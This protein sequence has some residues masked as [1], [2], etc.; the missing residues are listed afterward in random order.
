MSKFFTLCILAVLLLSTFACA[1]VITGTEKNLDD[2]IAKDKVSI[3]KFYAPWCGHC[4]SLA[5]EFEKAADALK[6][7]ASLVK[8][9]CTVEKKLA[10]KYDIKGFPTLIVFRKGEKVENYEGGR[11]AEEI[12]SYVRS[13]S[14]PLFTPVKSQK[15][16]DELIAL[17]LGV[18][19]VKTASEDGDVVT[20]LTPIAKDLSKVVAFAVGTDASIA[21][22]APMESI[23]FYSG[24]KV[25]KYT[26][27]LLSSDFE[28]KFTKFL[29]FAK[30]ATFGEVTP[31]SFKNYLDISNMKFPLGYLFVT[32]LVCTE[33]KAVKAIAEKMRPR[34]IFASVD[35][36]LYGGF[37][38]QLSLPKD[39][40]TGFVIEWDHKHYV[41]PLDKKIESK[42]LEEFITAVL[43]KKISPTLKSE[44]AP[45]TETTN[46]LTTLVGTTF[47]KY[48]QEKKPMFVLFYAP[49][50]GHCKKLHPVF[51]KLAEAFEKEDVLIAK[52]DA[53]ENDVDRELFEVKGFPTLYFIKNGAG[54]SYS[55]DRTLE[56][57]TKFVRSHMEAPSSD[58]SVDL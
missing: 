37:G 42:A 17:G 31:S 7:Q 27:D 15:E 43:D 18:A 34:I 3:V 49:W 46:G 6:E 23:V 47:A 32:T 21:A 28:D 58:D 41:F 20:R 22:D 5:P 10:E 52:L 24:G 33:A 25:H 12:I 55:G 56:D 2:I 53:T 1:E 30:V 39:T 8:V 11:T 4:K 35:S 40:K 9:D 44:E 36:G 19:L 38:E 54:I 45:K 16:L 50:C 48:V 26:D 13:L 29:N 57:M 14:S 51:D